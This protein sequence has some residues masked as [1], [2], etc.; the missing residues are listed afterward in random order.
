MG[1]IAVGTCQPHLRR[2]PSSPGND[3]VKPTG[4]WER[5]QRRRSSV[6]AHS[7]AVGA[8]RASVLPDQAGAFVH[9]G[10][11]SANFFE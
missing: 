8:P 1:R 2:W 9:Y 7:I 6:A 5:Q 10:R 4:W 3:R 11:T